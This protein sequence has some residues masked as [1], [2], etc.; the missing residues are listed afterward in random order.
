MNIHEICES[1]TKWTG[2]AANSEFSMFSLMLQNRHIGLFTF[3]RRW[4]HSP[5]LSSILLTAIYARM[6]TVSQAWPDLHSPNA[7]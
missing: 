2:L 3:T 7:F 4:H 1:G 5:I 6:L